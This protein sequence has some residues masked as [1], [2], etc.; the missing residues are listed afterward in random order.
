MKRLRKYENYLSINNSK[1]KEKVRKKWN[2][3]DLIKSKENLNSQKK[4]ANRITWTCFIFDSYIFE[5]FPS[6]V[7]IAIQF[8]L[9]DMNSSNKKNS[10]C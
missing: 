3:Q 4:F 7:S 10:F 5:Y 6:L 2:I 8:Y 9:R 1:K